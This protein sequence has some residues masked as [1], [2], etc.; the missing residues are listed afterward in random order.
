MKLRRFGALSRKVVRGS[1]NP[2]S[3]TIVSS[4]LLLWPSLHPDTVRAEIRPRHEPKGRCR[5]RDPFT[6]SKIASTAE[7]G[8]PHGRRISVLVPGPNV[9]NSSARDGNQAPGRH[10]QP[11]PISSFPYTAPFPVRSPSHPLLL[12]CLQRPLQ[13]TCL[14]WCMH[15]KHLRSLGL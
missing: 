12:L 10:P 15:C 1:R 7:S 9:E 11:F 2:T 13:A 5:K 8:R 4:D 14:S 6:N 3:D